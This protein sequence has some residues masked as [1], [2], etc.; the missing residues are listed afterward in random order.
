MKNIKKLFIAIIIFSIIIYPLRVYSIEDAN[1]ETEVVNEE[2]TIDNN[3]NGELK[4]EDTNKED[5]TDKTV[6]KKPNIY[7]TTHVENIGWQKYVSN[8]EMAGTT[9]KALRLEGI[10]IKL[11]NEPGTGNIEY[12]THIESIGWETNFKKNDEMSGTTGKALRLEAIEIKLTGEIA[13]HYDVYYRVHSEKY[14]W[15]G[16]AKNG[17]KAGTAGFAYRLEGIEIKIVEKDT[18]FSECGKAKAFRCKEVLY[19]THVQDYG[20]QGY[21]Y[22][23]NT[24]GTTGKAKKIEGIKIKL[25]NQQYP[26][27]IEYKTHIENIGWESVYKKNN[28]LSGTTGRNLRVEA[29]RIKLTGE[30][31]NHYDFFFFFFAQSYG[32]LGWTKNDE[33]AGTI[34]YGYRLEAI[35]IKLVPKGEAAPG[36]TNNSNYVRELRYRSYESSWKGF[37]YDGSQSGNVST[38]VESITMNLLNALYPGNINYSSYVT[39]SGWQKIVKDGELTNNPGNKIEAI[40]VNITGE[41]ANHYDVFYSVYVI[42]SGWTGWAKNDSPCGNIGNEKYITSYKVKLVQKGQSQGNTNNTYIEAPMSIKYT[43]NVTGTGWQNYV[44][45]GQT[46]GTTGKAKSIKGVKIK[47][48]KKI[49][50]GSVQYSTHVSN[51]GWQTYSQDNAQSGKQNTVEA[52]KIR[53]TGELAND[54]DIYYRVHVSDVGWM[55]WTSNNK[56]AGT[57]NGSLGVEAIEIQLVEKGGPAPENTNNIKTTESYLEAHWEADTNGNRYFFDVFGEMV[58]GRGYKMGTTTYYFGPSGIFLGTQNLQI[59]DISAHQ[60]VVDWNAVAHSDVYGVILR[61]AASAQYR[62]S[63]LKENVAACKKYGIPYGIYIYSYAEN[64]TEGQA[65]ANFTNALISE[66]DIHPTLGIFLDLESNNSTQFMGP[67]QYEAVVRG[68]YSI[69]PNAEIYTYTSYAD[70]ALNSA[71]IRNKI[72]WIADWRGY[73]GYTG[74]YRMWQYTSKGSCPGVNGNVD[75]SI[76]YSF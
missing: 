58:K 20:W 34:G 68:Y 18:P 38:P 49:P 59:L 54:Y 73:V 45:D 70:T 4:T 40:K 25:D 72:T 48:N 55:G 17:E 19:S 7:Y 13:N 10:K 6:I 22:D 39:G 27:N 42:G 75:R 51:V 56:P 31:S 35:E 52:I 50:S 32:W 23:G 30:I 64:Y 11:D 1:S 14:G 29:I 8:G 46:S 63:K 36:N 47:V 21:A 28:E 61:V 37:V 24:S 74:S 60:G 44:S 43:S 9:G 5:N 62:D 16:W 67:T 12:R 66:F 41:I 65:Y 33:V 53:L 71:Y 26:G 15:L 3:I 69:I 2:N 57:I 76:L